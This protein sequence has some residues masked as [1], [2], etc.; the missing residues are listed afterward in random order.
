MR[1]ANGSKAVVCATG[2]AGLAAR[3]VL[4]AAGPWPAACRRGT[5]RLAGLRGGAAAA[6]RMASG[7]PAAGLNVPQ[8]PAPPLAA[9]DFRGGQIL[10]AGFAVAA[11][12]PPGGARDLADRHPTGPP[13]LRPRGPGLDQHA[14]SRPAPQPAGLLHQRRRP[15]RDVRGGQPADRSMLSSAGRPA[16]HTPCLIQVLPRRA[17]P[18]TCSA[19]P[20]TFAGRPRRTRTGGL[21]AASPGP[22]L[23]SCMPM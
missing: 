23:L 12:Q 2:P 10:Q 20:D 11:R 7:V 9:L 19:S 15:P 13:R 16:H 22:D 6:G 1:D 17:V 14:R 8:R 3:R 21:S 4:V 18:L 5:Q